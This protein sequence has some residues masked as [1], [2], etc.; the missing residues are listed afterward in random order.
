M[1]SRSLGSRGGW[2]TAIIRKDNPSVLSDSVTTCHATVGSLSACG[3]TANNG[4]R[5]GHVEESYDEGTSYLGRDLYPKQGGEAQAHL[6]SLTRQDYD[7]EWEL[8]LVNNGSTDDTQCVI[9]DF[10]K[11]CTFPLWAEHEPLSGRSRA[12]NKG[13]AGARG[14]IVAYTDDD[15]YPREDF[16]SAIAAR[17]G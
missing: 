4:S 9:D 10:A 5:Y 6:R 15:C 13:L 7:G 17:S 8:I 1:L 14:E 3:H 12:R 16:L 11:A 2:R